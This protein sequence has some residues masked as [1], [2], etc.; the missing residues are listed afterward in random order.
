[1]WSI[2]FSCPSRKSKFKF[3]QSS[4]RHKYL[5]PLFS[6]DSNFLPNILKIKIQKICL[7]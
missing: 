4:G 1:M 5:T 7:S 6:F 2:N 3:K